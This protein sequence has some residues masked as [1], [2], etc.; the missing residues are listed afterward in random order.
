MDGTC[1]SGCD[2]DR[3]GFVWGTP[4][5][6][7]A[8]PF[9]MKVSGNALEI[10]TAPCVR[11]WA[12]RG[13]CIILWIDDILFLVRVVHRSVDHPGAPSWFVLPAGRSTGPTS[14]I[15][16]LFI[17]CGGRPTCPDCQRA[18]EDAT[19]LR[20]QVIAEITD[21]GWLTN[22]K[23]SGPPDETGE[24]IG[25]PF[26]TVAFTFTLPRD[27][28]GKLHRRILKTLQLD[29]ISRRRLAK[30]RGKLM[31]YGATLEFTPIMTRAMSTWI[32]NP[33]S[34]DAWDAPNLRSP[35][36]EAE[37]HFWHDNLGLLA[38]RA[39]PIIP[40]TGFQLHSFWLIPRH[41]RPI[42][43][44]SVAA[45]AIL[46]IAAV[47]YVDA[48]IHGFGMVRQEDANS[49]PEVVVGTPLPGEPWSEQ[50]HREAVA[51]SHAA[52]L[53]VERA[54]GRTTILVSDCA[55]CV[56]AL[57]KGSRSPELQACAAHVAQQSISTN[58]RLIP[59]WVPGKEL[60]ERGVDAL[61]RTA[62]LALHDVAL[63]PNHLTAIQA[64]A[65]RYLGQPLSV[66]W[67]ASP[68]TAQLPR[69]WTRYADPSSEGLDAFLAPS[70]LASPCP[71]GA[72]HREI[73][74]FFP[75]TPL[76]G[77]TLARIKQ[78]GACGVIVVPRTPGAPWWPVLEDCS[79]TYADLDLA[80][81][82]F[83]YTAAPDK[84]YSSRK[85]TWQA[86]AFT[87]G[88]SPPADPCPVFRQ[89]NPKQLFPSH[90]RAQDIWRRI[91]RPAMRGPSAT[92][93]SE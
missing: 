18:F 84:L 66:D 46:D 76:I 58:S 57:T 26:D 23:A 27:K 39:R 44:P 6:L 70:W 93:S 90:D 48:S 67:F 54:P 79:I 22:E 78:E 65:C 33:T 47:I 49:D 28:R 19:T 59:M 88:P 50:V 82:P 73:G 51:L 64:L 34:D 15:Q 11:R 12:R 41:L 53:A 38:E 14:D 35:S 92:R 75:P 8:P 56:Q 81:T 86:H 77:K 68:A 20:T 31:W 60:V 30:L 61:S 3:L 72:L 63:A 37:L 80:S 16:D 87:V 69:Y 9:G 24:F 5:R 45:A 25:I 1:R 40:L 89:V 13:C 43:S 85:M 2:K 83:R 71:C 91:L 4:F 7:N 21:L 29:L 42:P 55:P 10:L 52:D 62:A 17:E 32:G 36:L 74:L